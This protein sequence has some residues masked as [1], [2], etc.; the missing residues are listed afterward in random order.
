[1]DFNNISDNNMSD[2]EKS[3]DYDNLVFSII[4]DKFRVLLIENSISEFINYKKL[5]QNFDCYLEVAYSGREGVHKYKYSSEGYYNL[6]I[7]DLHMT[8]VDGYTAIR[9][10]RENIDKKDSKTIPIV[11]I[12]DF[13]DKKENRVINDDL[14]N[15]FNC[16]FVKKDEIESVISGAEEK[17]RKKY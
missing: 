12:I 14:L 1:M 4:S 10:I 16:I 11:G 9:N 5:I 13:K 17:W 6:I 8:I 2:I 7:V 3:A 15:K